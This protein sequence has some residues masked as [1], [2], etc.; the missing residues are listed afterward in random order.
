MVVREI[1]A[2]DQK[3]KKEEITITK[4]RKKLK[5][6]TT[7]KS[8]YPQNQAERAPVNCIKIYSNWQRSQASWLQTV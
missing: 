3:T 8:R 7:S 1:E 4:I 5:W 2:W 6:K